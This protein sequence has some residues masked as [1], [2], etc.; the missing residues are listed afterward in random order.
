MLRLRLPLLG[1]PRPRLLLLGL[2]R[3]RLHLLLPHLLL[4]IGD[5][6][7]YVVYMA[8]NHLFRLLHILIP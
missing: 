2:P 7:E 4:L 8:G 6:V 1:L 5:D 3:P